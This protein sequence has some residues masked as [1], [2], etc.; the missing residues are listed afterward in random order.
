MLL[1][2]NLGGS[3]Y[4][5]QATGNCCPYDA[6]KSHYLSDTTI[7]NALDTGLNFQ[8]SKDKLCHNAERF[9]WCFLFVW[10]ELFSYGF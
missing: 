9:L 10:P 2:I 3:D 1:F 7:T 8:T 6:F 5:R 4:I